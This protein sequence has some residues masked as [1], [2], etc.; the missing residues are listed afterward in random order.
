MR[1]FALWGRCV[2][3]QG[4]QPKRA[5]VVVTM[6]ECRLMMVNVQRGQASGL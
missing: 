6:G 4:I 5:L 3:A 1:W 2:L